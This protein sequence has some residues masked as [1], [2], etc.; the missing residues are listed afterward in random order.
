MVEVNNLLTTSDGIL[1]DRSLVVTQKWFLSN[2]NSKSLL[3][4]SSE[5][6]DTYKWY[7]PFTFTIKSNLSFSNN[8]KTYW[9]RPNDSKCIVFFILSL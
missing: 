9:L 6:Y 5:S 8:I 7:V 3:K 1:Y 2:P 4:L